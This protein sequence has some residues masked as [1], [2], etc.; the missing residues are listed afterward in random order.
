MYYESICG[1]SN[2]QK[3]DELRYD[4]TIDEH[5]VS[6]VYM[7]TMRRYIQA[8]WFVNCVF[9]IIVDFV[10]FEICWF[11]IDVNVRIVRAVGTR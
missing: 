3:V 9:V 5:D 1:M 11:A 4:R 8:K 10:S 7:L 2:L 6:N